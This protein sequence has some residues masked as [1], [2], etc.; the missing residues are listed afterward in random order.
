MQT[1]KAVAQAVERAQPHRAQVIRQHG[2]QPR[3]HFLGGF[4]GERDRQ[5]AVHARHLVLQQPSNARGEYARF[6]AACACQ[7]QRGL[8]RISYSSKLLGV[9]VV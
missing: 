4:V 7:H 5:N 2:T 1:Q 3:L 8:R 9:K 6:A